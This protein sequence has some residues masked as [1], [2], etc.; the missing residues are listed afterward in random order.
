MGELNLPL[1]MI[2]D[3]TLNN[4]PECGSD[5]VS[6]SYFISIKPTNKPRKPEEK[7]KSCGF[8]SDYRFELLNKINRRSEKIDKILD[9]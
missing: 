9:K 5:K 4:C 7:C 3:R 1:N 2:Y 6:H 8:K